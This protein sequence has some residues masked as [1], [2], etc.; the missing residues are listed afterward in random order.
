MCYEN[1]GRSLTDRSTSTAVK[2]TKTEKLKS[3][4]ASRPRDAKGR[5]MK[6][7]KV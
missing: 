2:Q 3:I 6:I 7:A 5:L 4:I 1:Y